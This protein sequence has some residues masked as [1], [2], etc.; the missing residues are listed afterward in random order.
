MKLSKI[1]DP[2]FVLASLAVASCLSAWCTA[3][4]AVPAVPTVTWSSVNQDR[5]HP[6][7]SFE[8]P[9]PAFSGSTTGILGTIDPNQ[10]S[11][12]LLNPHNTGFDGLNF[13]TLKGGL[14]PNSGDFFVI[15][16]FY[17]TPGNAN[18]D[19]GL[20]F[21]V[22]TADGLYHSAS[23]NT[24][25]PFGSIGS[26]NVGT[27]N[28][29]TLWVMVIECSNPGSV[30]TNNFVP[31]LIPGADAQVVKIAIV[32]AGSTNTPSINMIFPPTF[33]GGTD[34]YDLLGGTKGRLF[35]LPGIGGLANFAVRV[36]PDKHFNFELP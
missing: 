8:Q 7:V 18:A 1:G 5:Y 25:N 26:I 27:N 23:F 10:P 31:P 21:V 28:G 36:Q 14:L 12:T 29:R 32:Y 19:K 4:M 6:L 2:R 11:F 16:S 33:A 24:P 34:A 22:Q 13:P 17:S 20:M 15:E 3:A 30:P 9:D 35:N